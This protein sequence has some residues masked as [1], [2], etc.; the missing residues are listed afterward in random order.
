MLRNEDV[1]RKVGEKW[2]QYVPIINN[3]AEPSKLA[4]EYNALVVMAK[5]CVL[6]AYKR[7][8]HQ[9]SLFTRHVLLVLLTVV[10]YHCTKG[11]QYY[12]HFL[13]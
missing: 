13:I 1:E 12:E 3:L 11:L 4:D 2:E 7:N 9:P 10:C 8:R 6:V 5:K